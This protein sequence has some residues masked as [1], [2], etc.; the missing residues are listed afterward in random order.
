M[1]IKHLS[2]FLVVFLAASPVISAQPT[3]TVSRVIDGAT[4]ELSNGEIVRLIGVECPT[5]DDQ[6]QN[7]RNADRLGIDPEHYASYAQKAKDHLQDTVGGEE[8]RI[9]FDELNETINHRDKYNR[10]LAYVY[11]KQSVRRNI[12]P[13]ITFA[14]VM[15][16]E[17]II[18]SGHSP[19]YTRF[20]FKHKD[21]F[22]GL[23]AEAKE[24]R[25]GMWAN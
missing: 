11:E 9:E 23:E 10:L 20:D 16:N 13:N 25:R 4:L 18:R 19:A 24:Q 12:D 3:H 17:S 21:K 2:V 7:K 8:V 14:W 6:E 5:L 15:L 22:L 1:H